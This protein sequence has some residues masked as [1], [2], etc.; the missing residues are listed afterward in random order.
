M[1]TGLPTS[2]KL[3]ALGICTALVEPTSAI[4]TYNMVTRFLWWRWASRLSTQQKPKAGA[5]SVGNRRQHDANAQGMAR[6]HPHPFHFM[7]K[8]YQARARAES[9]P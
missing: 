4:A 2:R 6:L 9:T 3:R 5:E 8:Y 7:Q 1:G